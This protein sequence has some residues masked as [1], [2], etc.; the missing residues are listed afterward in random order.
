MPPMKATQGSAGLDL[1]AMANI[2][3]P[4]LGG[5]V[6]VKTGIQI[7]LPSGTYGRVA[8]RS[9]LARDFGIIIGGGKIRLLAL[10]SVNYISFL[11]GVIDADYRGE[12]KGDKNSFASMG[13]TLFR[14]Y[15]PTFQ[16]EY[17]GVLRQAGKQNSSAGN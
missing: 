7:F 16:S 14:F 17:E 4:P 2:V 11:S 12:I 10:L 1:S 15:S 3:I 13:I 9:G 8:G 6:V 5:R